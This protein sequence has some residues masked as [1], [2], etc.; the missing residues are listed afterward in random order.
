MKDFGPETFGELNAEGYDMFHDPGTTEISVERI[1]EVAGSG[2]ILE[3]AIGTG[4]I[5]LP[6]LHKGFDVAGIEGSPLMVDKLREKP[7]GDQIDVVIGD[8]ADVD[9]DGTYD[10]ACLVFNTLFNLP[11]QDAQTRCF[12]NT[13]KR[14]KPGG[15]FLVETYVPDVSAFKNHQRVSTRNLGKG[16][17]VIEAVL[18]D[19][20]RQ[21]FEF[22]RIHFSEKGTRL[23]PLPMRYAYPPEMDLMAQ[24]AGLQ[25]RDRWSGWN[26]EPFTADSKMH[27]SVYEKQAS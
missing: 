24:L 15:T 14:M 6:L 13:A 22:Q 4:R 21:T 25:L 16:F 9:I 23:V 10:H 11:S 18:H 26:K 20:V 17:V 5:A 19:P 2:R 1:A 7:G 12:A 3:L 8:F 27:V